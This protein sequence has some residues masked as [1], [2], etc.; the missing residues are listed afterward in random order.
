MASTLFQSLVPIWYPNLLPKDALAFFRQHSG[1]ILCHDIRDRKCWWPFSH[2]TCRIHIS[3]LFCFRLCGRCSDMA[4]HCPQNFKTW[5]T[6]K[7]WQWQRQKNGLMQL[8]VV[9][10]GFNATQSINDYSFY[11]SLGF[12]YFYPFCCWD[13]GSNYMYHHLVMSTF[14]PVALL[15]SVAKRMQKKVSN[16]LKALSSYL[17]TKQH[18]YYAI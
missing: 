5:W 13:H 4:P 8:G 14:G 17:W 9:W 6:Q 11:C 16:K 10:V 18:W 15:G 12:W 7:H 2:N 3:L 1:Q